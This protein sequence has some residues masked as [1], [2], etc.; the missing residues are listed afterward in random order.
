MTSTCAPGRGSGPGRA[1]S[2]NRRKLWLASTN[3]QHVYPPHLQHVLS[4]RCRGLPHARTPC[5]TAHRCF[6]YIGAFALQRASTRGFFFLGLLTKNKQKQMWGWFESI[7]YKLWSI[8]GGGPT[9]PY[10]Y[11]AGLGYGLRVGSGLEKARFFLSWFLWS[12]KPVLAFQMVLAVPELAA[13]QDQLALLS[14]H[15][16]QRSDVR[17]EVFSSVHGKNAIEASQRAHRTSKATLNP[18]SYFPMVLLMKT[19]KV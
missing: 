15:H 6:R 1:S 7:C 18:K 9:T 11:D 17:A 14:F 8:R 2:G 3:S 4:Y 12:R 19:N 5:P 16:V 13:L 10:T